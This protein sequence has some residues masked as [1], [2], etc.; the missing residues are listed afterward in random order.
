MPA[1]DISDVTE[2]E[3]HDDIH[4]DTDEASTVSDVLTQLTQQ[5]HDDTSYKPHFLMMQ[6]KSVQD[7]KR[8]R[9]LSIVDSFGSH[10]E[11]KA[12]LDQLIWLS[13]VS[14]YFNKCETAN[15]F[16]ILC[17]HFLSM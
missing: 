12:H 14:Q 2:E 7:F 5:A 8:Q 15:I 6:L 1:Y 11:I 10:I 9:D 4:S 3:Y 17:F 16:I 13:D